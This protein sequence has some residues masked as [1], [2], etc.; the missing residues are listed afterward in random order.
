MLV[1]LAV[2]LFRF[3][4]LAAQPKELSP[5][6]E[7]RT[8]GRLTG[9][10]GQPFARPL[11]FVH[12][13]GPGAM[14]LHQFGAAYQALTA[15]GHQVRLRCTP[16]GQRRCPL[17]RPAQIEDFVAGFDH[18]AIDVPGHQRGHLAGRDGDHRLV[19]QGDAL[20]RLSEPDQ[21][22]TATVAGH[23]AQVGVAEPISDLA[24]LDER[25]VPG[26]RVTRK[27]C[28]SATGRRR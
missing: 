14:Q 24:G 5:L 11:R 27:M 16:A 17:L 3:C 20:S 12:G 19:E 9:R 1:G 22:A 10:L 28:R 13:S 4:E 6:V 23:R 7:G 8:N 21:R 25:L 26:C 18:A 2:G 15:I